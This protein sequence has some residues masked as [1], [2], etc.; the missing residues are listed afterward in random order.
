MH[1]WLLN[2]LRL[3]PAQSW[4]WNPYLPLITASVEARLCPG[5]WTFLYPWAVLVH[6][7][8][9]VFAVFVLNISRTCRVLCVFRQVWAKWSH[10][11]VWILHTQVAPGFKVVFTLDGSCSQQQSAAARPGER[12][13]DCACWL[14]R[15]WMKTDA[16]TCPSTCSS[17]LL[18][19][20]HT[21]D[22]ILCPSFGAIYT[23]NHTKQ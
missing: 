23:N 16:A 4:D 11:R 20:V 10:W 2:C 15:C 8:Y 14:T 22:L 21:M 18:S 9:Y 12:A 3:Q 6:H 7:L 1:Q 19:T 17:H 13:A 5:R